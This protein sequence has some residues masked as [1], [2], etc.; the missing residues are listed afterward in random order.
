MILMDNNLY[1]TLNISS[2]NSCMQ[3]NSKHLNWL[4]QRG[5]IRN[6]FLHGQISEK[7]FSFLF[8]KI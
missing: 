4:H 5:Y 2:V 8:D 7:I 1:T 6:N 3:T